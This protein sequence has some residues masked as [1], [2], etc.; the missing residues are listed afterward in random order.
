VTHNLPHDDQQ[1]SDVEHES[2]NENSTSFIPIGEMDKLPNKIYKKNKLPN[3]DV[4]LPWLHNKQRKI[5]GVASNNNRIPWIRNQLTGND[6]QNSK[7]KNIRDHSRMQENEVNGYNSYKETSITPWKVKCHGRGLLSGET[8]LK[9][10]TQEQESSSESQRIELD[11]TIVKGK[12]SSIVLVSEQSKLM[13]WKKSQYQRTHCDNL[14]RRIQIGMGSSI[15]Q[16]SN[17]RNMEQSHKTE[18]HKFIRTNSS[19]KCSTQMDLYQKPDSTNQERQYDNMPSLPNNSESRA[20]PRTNIGPKKPRYICK[21]QEPPYAKICT[22]ETGLQSNSYGRSP[23][24]IEGVEHM[25]QPL[26]DPTTQSIE[27]SHQRTSDD[28]TSISII[29]ISTMVSD[30]HITSRRRSQ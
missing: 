19:E 30:T 29:A 25:S 8:L 24:P 5:T 2:Y 22:L 23:V 16:G 21:L 14:Y 1:I 6:H 9:S 12:S 18:S 26:M 10:F 28:C 15:E 27:Q 11:D 4:K 13:K 17:M 3:E 7:K 20:H